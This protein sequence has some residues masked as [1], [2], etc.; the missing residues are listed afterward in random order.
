MDSPFKVL[1]VLTR[2]YVPAIALRISVLLHRF[3]LY[4]GVDGRA[5]ANE[6]RSTIV[7]GKCIE[8]VFA[9]KK[10]AIQTDCSSKENWVSRLDFGRD[11]GQTQTLCV[12]S[13]VD[14]VCALHTT[15]ASTWY[16]S[17]WHLG[18]LVYYHGV[19]RKIVFVQA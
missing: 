11:D 4:E 16:H 17:P 14:K 1:D 12:H 7:L 19:H 18:V 8:T 5:D 9:T 2:A 13:L 3:G 6:V 15:A 10:Q